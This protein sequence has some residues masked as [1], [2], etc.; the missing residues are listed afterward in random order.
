MCVYLFI[1]LGFKGQHLAVPNKCLHKYGPFSVL[2]NNSYKYENV[3]K[4]VTNILDV[5]DSKIC[6][7]T[8]A[9]IS[10]V[11]N[12]SLRLVHNFRTWSCTLVVTYVCVVG[13]EYIFL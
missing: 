5:S 3:F 13:K 7:C 8:F 1:I 4:K 2:D 12:W 9:P 11:I 10:L 6:C